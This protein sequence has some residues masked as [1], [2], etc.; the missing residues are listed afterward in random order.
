[1]GSK[2]T[3]VVIFIYSSF[4]A[5]YAPICL[6]VIYFV[7][8]SFTWKQQ[9]FVVFVRSAP[10]CNKGWSPS[11]QMP[12]HLWLGSNE[13]K[14]DN[15]VIKQCFQQW[16]RV[17]LVHLDPIKICAHSCTHTCNRVH[18]YIQSIRSSFGYRWINSCILGDYSLYTCS[19]QPLCIWWTL[20]GANRFP[21]SCAISWLVH[22]KRSLHKICMR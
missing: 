6:I 14:N 20:I 5:I 21:F 1:M 9:A 13:I 10:L 8:W 4:W 2:K 11:I 16:S 7:V 17:L 22:F 18:S 12:I 19:L 3:E 15:Q